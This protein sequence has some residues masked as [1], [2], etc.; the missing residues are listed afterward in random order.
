M[1]RVTSILLAVSFILLAVSGLSMMVRHG[2]GAGHGPPSMAGEGRGLGPPDGRERGPRFRAAGP[3][4]EHR[5][6]LFPVQL[7]ELGALVM[8]V[9]G[10]VHITLNWKALLCHIGLRRRPRAAPVP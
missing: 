8:L 1:R 9:A 3:P 7:H 10:I 2:P 6:P 5:E 4:G